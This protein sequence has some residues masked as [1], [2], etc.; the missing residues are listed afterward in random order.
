VN[1]PIGTVTF[2]FTDIEGST[3]QWE[4]FAA[5]MRLALARHD[6]ILN[7]AI[8]DHAGHVIKK[9]GD[10]FHAVFASAQDALAAVLAVQFALQ[11]EPWPEPVQIL[12]RIALHSGEAQLRDDDYYG[13]A[14]NRAARLMAVAHGGQTLLSGTTY[15]LL[16]HVLP[17]GIGFRDLGLHRLKD[18]QQPEQVFQLLHPDLPADFPSLKSLDPIRTNL[19]VQL[20]SFIGREAEIGE[21][22]DLLS[23]HRLL[24][25]M[26]AGGTGKTRL[27]LQVGAERLEDYSGGVWF[28]ELAALTEPSL[29]AQSVANAL[30][31]R[32]APGRSL[33]DTL[34]DFLKSRRLLLILDNCEHLIE[35]CADLAQRLLSSCPHLS[36]LATSREALRIGA[37]QTY[38][39]PALPI[40]NLGGLARTPRDLPGWVGSFDAVR[41][42]VDRARLVR[43]EFALSATNAGALASICHRLDGIPLA[44]ELAAARVRALSAE[45]IDRRLDQRFRLLTGGSRAALP[46]QQTLRALIDWSYDLLNDAEKLLLARLS[47]FSGGWTLEAAEAICGDACNLRGTEPPQRLTPDAQRPFDVL[48]LLTSLVDKSLVFYEERQEGEARYRLLETVREYAGEKLAASGE[49]EAVRIQH[50]D[51]YLEFAEQAHPKLMGPEQREWLSRLD[52]E[53]NNLRAALA[54]SL[55]RQG[56]DVTTAMRFCVFL[57]R[58]WWTWGYLTEGRKWCEAALAAAN[59]SGDRDLRG[60]VLNS[61]GVMAQM[62]GDYVLALAYHADSL[63]IQRGIGNRIGIAHSLNGLGNVKED[64]GDYALARTYHEES[65]L[66]KREIG[67]RQGIAYSLNNLGTLASRQGDYA[68]ARAYYEESLTLLQA[69]GDQ[70]A[71]ASLLNNL[72]NVTQDQGDYASARAYHEESLA[73]DKELG[74]QHGVANSLNNLGLMVF[75]QGDYASARTYHEES[76]MIKREI[77]D[78]QGISNSLNNLGNVASHQG[79][80]ASARAYYMESLAIKREIGYPRGI[81]SSLN[82][83]GLVACYQGDY[84]SARFYHNES[85]AIEREIGSRIGVVNSL[86]ALMA[87]ETALS[88]VTRAA[89][90]WGAAVA[91]REEIG[92]PLPPNQQEEYRR[93]LDVVRAK[94]GE[95]AFAVA[96]AAGRAMTL[97]D[98]VAFALSSQP[99]VPC[100]DV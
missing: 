47:V 59:A 5:A 31:L 27:A 42:F 75:C 44:I 26:G 56:E 7:W 12:A 35:A 51:R 93:R 68:S 54:W 95:E 66:I 48:D 22:T 39:V 62:Q 20:T 90:L 38:R 78:R 43:S 21:I 99:P 76:L 10:G 13:G 70:H 98:A 29:V 34:T 28:I 14:V 61:V 41:L 19:P 30:T 1:L 94:L 18:L 55:M 74:N 2:L 16:G 52:T 15:S 63:E 46:R 89:Q 45:E 32:E 36:I 37:E 84:A 57:A 6:A 53:H 24:T 71:I 72:G 65:L 81:A 91:L 97:D 69:I 50:R 64:Q 60:K 100:Q 85:L 23:R 67:D 40:P 9:T 96:L 58:F 86:E 82:N 25:V 83:L 77:G 3:K 88:A 33:L 11:T 17:A 87:L 79:D 49:M 8:A 80:Y 92:A 4:Q 73:I